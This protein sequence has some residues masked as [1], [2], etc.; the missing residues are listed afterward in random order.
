MNINQPG[1]LMFFSAAISLYLSVYAWKRKSDP[2]ILAL[3]LL[4]FAAA[5][6]SIG[7][8]LE[9]SSVDFGQIKFFGFIAYIGI[10]TTPILW[11]IFAIRY[12][13]K[14]Q[15]LTKKMVLLFF[16]VPL[17]TLIMIATNEFHH[18][19]YTSVAFHF[20]GKYYFQE[21]HYGPMWYLHAIWSYLSGIFGMIL[22]AKMLLTAAKENRLKISY[23][24]LGSLMPYAV[25][26]FYISGIRPFGF[27][28]L[29]PVAFIFMGALLVLGAHK[30][31]LFDIKPLAL[32]LLFDNIHD[33]IFVLNESRQITN[34]NP[35][36]R[37]LMKVLSD[38][39]EE[40]SKESHQKTSEIAFLIDSNDTDF[41]INNKTYYRSL[42]E[43]KVA[44]QRSAGTLLIL[45]D[46]TEAKKAEKSL[47]ESENR[48]R[49]ILENMP[50]LL[51]AFDENGLFI[52]WNK[53]CEKSTGYSSQEIIGNP[54]A[55]RMLYPDE[56]YLNKVILSSQNKN[57]KQN[58]YDLVSKKGEI[59]TITWFD[60]YHFLKIPGWSSWGLGIDV[61]DSKRTENALFM[62]E[63]QLRELN[64]SKDKFFSIIAHDLRSPFNSILGLSDLLLEFVRE[65]DM[66]SLE[67]YIEVIQKTSKNTYD[68]VVNLLE[69]S[70]SQIGRLEFSPEYIELV[71]F[72]EEE[73]KV[74]HGVAQSKGI[75]IVSDFP[76]KTLVFADKHMLSTIIRNLL[77]NAIKF[78]H[79]GGTVFIKSSKQP[80]GL[81]IH[82]IDEGIGISQKDITK[83]FKLEENFTTKGT[84]NEKG[85]GLG[86]LLCKEFV[87]KHNGHIWVE[88]KP[89]SGSNFSFT[90]PVLST[91][92]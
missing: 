59:R 19:F 28:D 65:G 66:D 36:A 15:W 61:T 29:T 14:D 39:K 50:I 64:T 35:A 6:W 32:N 4:L 47:I 30:I 8:G 57:A 72:I 60:T 3:S 88:S 40:E 21:L 48:F 71:S 11:M 84:Q 70:Q 13:Q 23:F 79:Q 2:A 87:E 76:S 10:A 22:F 56:N 90:L 58:T 33:P 62:S 26:Y 27:L 75:T 18:L 9:I 74:L 43:I 83:L 25:N 91:E 69:W 89:G 24:I 73:T 17:L 68:L 51:N 80:K 41:I 12:T 63:Q 85:T 46:I 81:A 44:N 92:L 49:L 16:S 20:D 86:L 5:I 53:A 78:S 45:R 77:S 52:V 31:K 38:Q 82:I 37:Q 67:K 42:S 1:L 34:S 55:M 7:Y 54:N